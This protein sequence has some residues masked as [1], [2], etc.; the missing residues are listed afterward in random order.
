MVRVPSGRFVMGDARGESDEQPPHEVSVS[1][2][3]IDSHEVTYAEY[4]SCVKRGACTPAH[5]DDKRC[6]IATPTG[7]RHVRVPQRYR[8]P[9]RPVVC[10]TWQQARAYCRAVG[11]R[12]PTEAEWEYAARAGNNRT[13]AWGD[14][15]PTPQR[16]TSADNRSPK[17]AGSFAPNQWGLH[18]MTGNVW[19]WT[20]DWYGRDYYRISDENDPR[21]SPV[22][23]Y[24]VLRGGG[25]YTGSEHL[26]V[27]NRQWLPPTSAE[28][29]VG[30]RCAK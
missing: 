2:F 4:D 27:R 29:S 5:Y 16:C 1:S 30:F 20:N 15:P 14:A 21:G 18:D 8:S 6:L 11:K 23:Q 19:E 7:F 10:V 26:R 12:L 24:K 22:G 9:D 13:Y 25:W 28:V 17:P 3:R